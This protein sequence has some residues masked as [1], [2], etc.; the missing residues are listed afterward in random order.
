M[1]IIDIRYIGL[2]IFIILIYIGSAMYMLQ[3]N[4]RL[5]GESNII[6]PIFNL[7]IVDST[8]NQYLLMLG[9]FNM[10]GFRYHANLA[11]CYLIFLFSTFIT[12]ITF[13]NMLIAIMGDTFDRVISQ[14]PTYSLKNKLKLMADMKS[15]INIMSRKKNEDDYKCYLYV[16]QPKQNYEDLNEEDDNWQGKIFHQQNFNKQKFEEVNTEVKKLANKQNQSTKEIK[17]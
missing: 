9:D 2:I 11:I 12:Q 15:T 6:Q 13:L 4:V 10:D 16:I 3:L 8:L 7:S 1:T 17:S 14:R 5:G